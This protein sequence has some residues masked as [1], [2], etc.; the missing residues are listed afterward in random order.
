[1]LEIE[2]AK[3]HL[4]IAFKAEGRLVRGD[5]DRACR[6]VLAIERALRPAQHF[7]LRHIEEI[8]QIAEATR[9]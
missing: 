7:D 3:A 1:L 9:E 2:I 8:E 6:G 4:G 5:V